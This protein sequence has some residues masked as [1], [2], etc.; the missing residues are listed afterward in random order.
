M[1]SS[2]QYGGYHVGLL[3]G[4]KEIAYSLLE[5]ARDKILSTA[6]GR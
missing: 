6:S 5:D 1:L 2:H 3:G 4:L